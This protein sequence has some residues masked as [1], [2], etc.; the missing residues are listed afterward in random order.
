[1]DRGEKH[2]KAFLF[3]D[4]EPVA[5]EDES[6]DAPAKSEKRA[7]ESRWEDGTVPFVSVSELAILFACEAGERLRR[8][9]FRGTFA[10]LRRDSPENFVTA[11]GEQLF[12]CAHSFRLGF[13]LRAIFRS[14]NVRVLEIFFGVN[15]LGGLLYS[16]LRARS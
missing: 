13:D 2:S 9:K 15:M 14:Q 10:N 5:P 11:A 7:R 3:S 16:C 8:E 12:F 6:R 1:M 4:E